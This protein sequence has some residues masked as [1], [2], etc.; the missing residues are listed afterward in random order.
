[1]IWHEIVNDGTGQVPVTTYCPLCTSGVAFDPRVG[2]RVLEFG[3]S[4]AL[5]QS[6]LVMYDRQ[7]ESLWTHFDGQAV[8]G[9]LARS[10]ERF[11]DEQTGSTWNVLGEAVEG[12]LVGERLEP[13]PHVDTF[14]FAWSAYQP[15]T[16]LVHQ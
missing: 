2:E 4:G 14:W 9:T 8:V 13:V 3:T 12:P 7:T 15:D 16:S 6:A 5:Y 10:G 1:M 11:V